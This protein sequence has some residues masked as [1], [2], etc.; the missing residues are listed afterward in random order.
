MSKTALVCLALLLLVTAGT[1]SGRAQDHVPFD[2]PTPYVG[3]RPLTQEEQN[4]RES[5]RHYVFGLLC[6]REDRLLEA[7]TAFE[8]AALLDPK[9]APVQRVLIRLYLALE[10]GDEALTA[11]SK[12]LTLDPDDYETWYLQARQCRARGKTNE[13]RAALE[14]ARTCPGVKERPEAHFQICHD[15]GM[16]C[17]SERNLEQ[18]VAAFTEAAEAVAHPEHLLNFT[19]AARAELALRAAETYERIGRLYLQLRRPD[20][21]V[22]AFRK[23]QSAH[24]DGAARLS[25]NLAQVCHELGRHE[26]ALG[27]LDTYLKLQPQGTEAYE[28]KM[29]LLGRLN[30]QKE[31]LPWLEQAAASDRYNVGLKLLLARQYVKGGQPAQAEKV[32]VELAEKG[33]APEVYQALFRLY[34]N[35]PALGLGKI[36]TTLDATFTVASNKDHPGQPV[37][38]AQARGM[39]VALREDPPLAQELLQAAPQTEG[40]VTR[41]ETFQVLAVLADKHRLYD[42]SERYYRLA[43]RRVGDEGRPLIYSGLLRALWKGNK[44]AEV[45]EVCREALRTAKDAD[46]VVYHAELARAL[47]RLERFPDALKEADSAVQLASATDKLAMRHLRVR[48]LV[49]ARE[50]VKA[51]AECLAL[52]KEHTLPGEVL[53]LRYLLS[54]VYSGA[55]RYDQAEKQLKL[56]LKLDPDNATVNNDLGYIMAER[57]KNLD[58]AEAMVRRAIELD[59]KR[60]QDEPDNAAYIDSLG[61]VLYRKGDYTGARRELERATTLPDSEDPVIWDHLGDTYRQLGMAEQARH[62]WQRA[63]QFYERDRRGR[64]ERRYNELRQKLQLLQSGRQP[65]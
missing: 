63:A 42:Q 46:C 34:H 59:R 14:K 3:L 1:R 51:E 29:G 19:P 2:R 45:A 6:Q 22:S 53:E 8:K 56:C 43:V 21:A 32:Y 61:W 31:L 41:F 23:A 65:R 27:H 58:Q 49:Q 26:E 50:Y 10:K 17:E 44:F 24:P 57:N 7:L 33:P 16:F 12:A 52:L 55:E 18:A 39:L 40:K 30:R 47:A 4:Q 38:A 28:M 64:M 15:L 5:L 9:A 13:A 35:E 37:A 36:L 48:V 25:F 62:A 11:T 20:P 60:R 54:G